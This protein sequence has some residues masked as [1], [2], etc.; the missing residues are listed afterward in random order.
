MATGRGR[1]CPWA[2]VARKRPATVS[3]RA[4]FPTQALQLARRVAYCR[5]SCS[6]P[7]PHGTDT[8]ENGLDQP[9]IHPSLEL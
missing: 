5:L 8:D 4:D 2:T 6:T 9:A 3:R 1:G 7:F